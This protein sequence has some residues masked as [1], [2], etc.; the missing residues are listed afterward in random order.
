M[1]GWMGGLDKLQCFNFSWGGSRGGGGGSIVI[2]ILVLRGNVSV[3]GV[4]FWHFRYFYI[5]ARGIGSP[6]EWPPTTKVH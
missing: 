6:T 5:K 1:S 4:T 2:E 3:T